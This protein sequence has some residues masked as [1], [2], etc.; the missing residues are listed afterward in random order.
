MTTKLEALRRVAEAARDVVYRTRD[1]WQPTP[2]HMGALRAALDALPAPQPARDRLAALEA[3]YAVV[4]D[5][6]R[7]T[8]RDARW[9]DVIAAIAAVEAA[10]APPRPRGGGGGRVIREPMQRRR[11]LL[12]CSYCGD[13]TPG[14][15]NTTPCADC[16]QMCNIVDADCIIVANHGGLDWVRER[17]APSKDPTP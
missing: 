11:V 9:S 6:D 15:T 8:G 13:D 1:D 2:W 7:A 4:R 12:L 17:G 14:C 3:L 5:Y 16:L 10:P